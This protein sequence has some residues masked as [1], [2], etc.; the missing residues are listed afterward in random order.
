MG[1]PIPDPTAP[2]SSAI[3]SETGELLYGIRYVRVKDNRAPTVAELEGAT[4]LGFGK[5]CA[6][7]PLLSLDDEDGCQGYRSDCARLGQC[8]CDR[9]GRE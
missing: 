2:E 8:Q 4:F 1:K 5:F 3:D 7:P 6:D 9:M